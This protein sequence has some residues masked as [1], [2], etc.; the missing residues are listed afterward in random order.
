VQYSKRKKRRL[1]EESGE[2]FQARLD[3]RVPDEAFPGKPAAAWFELDAR[4][5]PTTDAVLEHAGTDRCSDQIAELTGYRAAIAA[6]ATQW[7]PFDFNSG[8]G[9]RDVDREEA[10]AAGVLPKGAKVAPIEKDFND[11]LQAGVKSLPE[12]RIHWLKEAFGDQVQ[13]LGWELPWQGSIV[14]DFYRDGIAGR[15]KKG[16]VKLGIATAKAI[17]EAARHGI[18]LRGRDLRLDASHARHIFAAHGPGNEKDPSQ[19]PVTPLDIEL[20]PHVWRDP[21]TVE[22]GRG[23]TL[24]FRKNLLGKVRI[25]EMSVDKNA[26]HI[27]SAF[28]KKSPGAG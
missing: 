15:R 21:D 24:L 4:E 27:T 19:R 7:P 26:A 1:P 11:E 17:A 2:V 12:D 20:L 8:M 14:G 22:K 13:Q 16:H 28:V 23:K 25:A 10:E 9:V 18:D 6:P 3:K 5:Q